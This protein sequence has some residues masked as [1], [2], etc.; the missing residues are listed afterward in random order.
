MHVARICYRSV[1]LLDPFGARPRWGHTSRWLCCILL[2]LLFGLCSTETAEAE[3]LQ[4]EQIEYFESHIRPV[5]VEHCQSCHNSSETAE[6]S[7]VLDFR[8]GLRRGGHQSAM[9]EEYLIVLAA[10]DFDVIITVTDRNPNMLQFSLSGWHDAFPDY[11]LIIDVGGRR[12]SVANYMS[13]A[14]DPS[15][16]PGSLGPGGNIPAKGGVSFENVTLPDVCCQ[17]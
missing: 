13:P 17:C 11:Q 9:P 4:P 8:D 1:A 2:S 10:I 14:S 12:L 6:G 3:P 15:M 7:L 16:S 5:L